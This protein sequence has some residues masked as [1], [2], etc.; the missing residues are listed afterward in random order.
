MSQLGFVDGWSFIFTLSLNSDI[1]FHIS[2]V[3]CLSVMVILA[4]VT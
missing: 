4:E 1:T 3:V 2:S